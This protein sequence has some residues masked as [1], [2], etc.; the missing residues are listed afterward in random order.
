MPQLSAV[1]LRLVMKPIVRLFLRNAHSYQTF[2]SITKAL[3]VEVSREDLSQVTH[4]VNTSRISAHTGINRQEIARILESLDNQDQPP[5][6]FIQKVISVW[7][8]DPDF[9]TKSHKARVISA[10]GAGSEFEKLVYKVSQ[11][12]NAGT[13]LFTLLSRGLAE[14]TSRGLKLN[15]TVFFNSGDPDAIARQ[16]AYDF[17]ALSGVGEE[18]LRSSP[19]PCHHLQTRYDNVRTDQLGKIRAWFHAE[20]RKFHKRARSFLSR[21]D[22]DL[23]PPSSDAVETG[24]VVILG[25]YG[26]TSAE[27]HVSGLHGAGAVDMG[28]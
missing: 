17:E 23:N 25:S 14:K 12:L 21:F 18:N 10:D 19:G 3:F 5:E 1:H 8:H 6:S 9:S 20:G 2:Q 4:K 16:L 28:D 24:A 27:Q 11:H 22:A 13:V 26:W 7:Q 15:T